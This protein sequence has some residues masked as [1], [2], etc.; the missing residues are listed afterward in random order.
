MRLV[1]ILL[2]FLTMAPSV[3]LGNI[4]VMRCAPGDTLSSSVHL[5]E[6]SRYKNLL[7]SSP[8]ASNVVKDSLMRQV[9]YHALRVPGF[10]STRIASM[11]L[12]LSAFNT[13]IR[14]YE[15]AQLGLKWANHSDFDTIKRLY[16][17]LGLY[18]YRDL[19]VDSALAYYKMSLL[20][21]DKILDPCISIRN[22]L[23]DIY[24]TLGQYNEAQKLLSPLGFWLNREFPDSDFK[25]HTDRFVFMIVLANLADCYLMLGDITNATLTASRIRKALMINVVPDDV[26]AFALGAAANVFASQGDIWQANEIF[27]SVFDR[28]VSSRI[29]RT[30]SNT[31]EFLISYARFIVDHPG[32]SKRD[33]E[34]AEHLSSFD[35][36]A[37]A[38]D[39]SYRYFNALGLLYVSMDSTEKANLYLREASGWKRRIDEANFRLTATMETDDFLLDPTVPVPGDNSSSLIMIGL[40]FMLVFC[41]II[42]SVMYLRLA[43][44][45]IDTFQR[46]KVVIEGPEA[47]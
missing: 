23:A 2:F 35:V 16:N 4:Q 3:I 25:D 32:V 36:D 11:Y 37:L 47:K 31:M 30:S 13:G 33:M 1:A 24:A 15:Y 26:S 17:N 21:C 46:S 5:Q 14:S 20:T 9:L 42:I 29:D 18:Y 28:L 39:K 10:D 40:I 44:K 12:N 8:D 45:N 22:N 34:V 41:V 27:E 38:R 19:E 7:I 6:Y 43:R